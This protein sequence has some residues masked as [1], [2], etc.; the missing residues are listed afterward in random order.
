MKSLVI[1]RI[2]NPEIKDPGQLEL[3]D[4]PVPEPGDED[5]LI[6]VAYACICGSDVHSLKGSLGAFSDRL[7]GRVPMTMGHEVSGVVV[8][9]GSTAEKM[10]FTPG[11]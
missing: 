9:A 6:Q 4:V 3:R 10:G 8:K 1:T 5:V 2:G 7:R 11:D